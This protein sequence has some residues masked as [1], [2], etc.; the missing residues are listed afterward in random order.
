MCNA[1]AAC[2]TFIFFDKR[3]Y[4][5]W[6]YNPKRFS[7]YPQAL[8]FVINVYRIFQNVDIDFTGNQMIVDVNH[9][10]SF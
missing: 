2:I 3:I 4:I 1:E 7:Q 5:F 9:T 6:D 8:V 10:L